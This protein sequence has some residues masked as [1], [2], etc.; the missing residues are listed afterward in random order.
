[1]LEYVEQVGYTVRHIIWGVNLMCGLDLDLHEYLGGANII[2][3]TP[4]PITGE[5]LPVTLG[6]EFSG[7]IEEVGIDV[8]DIKVG[9][10]VVVQPIIYDSIC[11]ACK[12]GLINCCDKGGF[13]GLS[14]MRLISSYCLG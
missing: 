12:E 14:G 9:E 3:T 8:N 5:K 6:H 2:P 7:V 1:M 10:R 11:S 4:H 13:L